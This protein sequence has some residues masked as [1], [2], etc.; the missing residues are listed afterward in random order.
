[1]E[2]KDGSKGL[3]FA[4]FCFVVIIHNSLAPREI[5]QELNEYSIKFY[6]V[7]IL[8]GFLYILYRIFIKGEK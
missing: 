7:A 6:G 2:D 4:I 8:L 5:R 1:M 3:M